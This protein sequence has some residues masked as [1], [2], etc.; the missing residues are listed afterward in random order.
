MGA[1]RLVVLVSL[2]GL[3]LALGMLAG[4]AQEPPPA[5]PPATAPASKSLRQ[6]YAAYRLLPPEVRERM[7]Q[8]DQELHKLEPEKCA[9]LTRAMHRYHEWLEA[10]K[11]PQR[12]RIEAAQSPEKRLEVIHEIREEQ[13]IATLPQADQD[14]IKAAKSDD[15]KNQIIAEL[16][17]REREWERKWQE[18]RSEQEFKRIAEQRKAEWEQLEKWRKEVLEPKLTPTEKDQLKRARFHSLFRIAIELADKHDV[19]PLPELL[20]RLPFPPVENQKL[21]DLLRGLPQAERESI[22]KRL[23]DPERGEEARQELIRLYWQKHPEELQRFRGPGGFP[24]PR[25]PQGG[26]RQ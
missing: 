8:L 16:R 26:P 10:L 7:R 2:G 12:Q 1:R 19:K 22:E 17:S 4:T 9:R 20:R 24:P 5:T 3:S 11:P 15:E 13:W 6:D 25:G 21:L 14:R 18:Q 23:V